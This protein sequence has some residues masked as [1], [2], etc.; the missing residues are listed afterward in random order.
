[1]LILPSIEAPIYSSA[2]KL[3][4]FAD[5]LHVLEE[6]VA[7]DW[8]AEPNL[9]REG[10]Y[11]LQLLN[12]SPSWQSCDSERGSSSVLITIPSPGTSWMLSCISE[13]TVLL[14]GQ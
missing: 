5:T 7:F 11:V 13:W 2:E 8:E 6:S 10:V 3:I 9:F 1:M 12:W 4:V 14:M